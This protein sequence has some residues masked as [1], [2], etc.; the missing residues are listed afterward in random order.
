MRW[1][2]GGIAILLTVLLGATPVAA[3]NTPPL[4]TW[5]CTGDPCP[6]GET[7][8]DYA[9]SW[10]AALNPTSVRLGYTTSEPVYLPIATASGITVTILSGAADAY[11]GAQSAPYRTWLARLESGQSYTFTS[12]ETWDKV[13][14]ESDV[15]FT[16][17][18]DIPEAGTSTPTLTT[19][20]TITPT[21]TTTPTQ[22]RIPTVEIQF[23]NLVSNTT[24]L[25]TYV[26]DAGIPDNPLSTL[27]YGFIG[28]IAG[29]GMFAVI[30]YIVWLRK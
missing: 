14:V 27:V 16:Y 20:A 17:T 23:T 5:T 12:G 25:M 29:F 28:M 2:T 30:G 13:S 18:L 9:V 4:V 10:P 7:M 15:I 19:T 24:N 6:Y 26:A 22:T 21:I 3:Q 1:I 11:T 8:S